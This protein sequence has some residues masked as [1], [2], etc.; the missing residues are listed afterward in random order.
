MGGMR[1]DGLLDGAGRLAIPEGSESAGGVP[2]AGGRVRGE[3]PRGTVAPK[4][5]GRGLTRNISMA[6][7][8]SIAQEYT[9]AGQGR[10]GGARRRLGDFSLIDTT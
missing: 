3:T 6:S 9:T 5:T 2:A 4:A 1:K 10:C 8:F 7:Q